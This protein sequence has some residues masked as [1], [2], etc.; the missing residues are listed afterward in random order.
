MGTGASDGTVDS[1]G[2][3]SLSRPRSHGMS[4]RTYWI[5]V[6]LFSV[7]ALSLYWPVL[8]TGFIIDDYAQLGMI[9]GTYP[10]PRASLA[11]FTFS[12]GSLVENASLRA[13][14]F[15][16][17]WSH[18]RLRISLF[19]PLASAIMWCDWFCF[20]HDAYAYHLHGAVWWL[21]MLLLW[22]AVARRL[23]PAWAALLAVALAALHPAQVGLLGWIANRNA[24]EASVFAL[25]A[26]LCQLRARQDGLRAG[27]AL[28]IACAALALSCSEYALGFLVY[29]PAYELDDDESPLAA[30]W[31]R[32]APWS[33][34]L[35]V[36]AGTRAALGFGARMSGM[37]ADPSLEPLPFL[38]GALE[39]YP[40][41]VGDLVL[42]LRANW[43]TAGFPWAIT[44]R[45]WGLV[46]PWMV[47]DIRYF[48]SI[49]VAL[50][51]IGIGVLGLVGWRAMRGRPAE[52]AGTS[53]AFV[54][55][56]LPLA[57]APLLGSTPE[58]RLMLPAAFGWS[59]LLAR[60]SVLACTAGPAADGGWSR[61]IRFSPLT[62]WLPALIIPLLTSASEARNVPRLAEAVRASILDPRL[63][64][65]IGADSRVLLAAAL[66]PTTTLYVPLLRRWYG[67]STP[68]SCHLLLSAAS[69]LR[70]ERLGDRSFALERA[71]RS[72]SASDAYAGIFNREPLREGQSVAAGALTATIERAVEGRPMRVRYE[73]DVSLDDPRTV[74][75]VQSTQGLL[76]RAFPMRGQSLWLERAL[77]PLDF[78]PR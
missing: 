24:L 56:A 39:R 21:G 1:I 19:R 37:Y 17:W 10:V 4:T 55:W 74:L 71:D 22:A 48:R 66:D 49:H 29:A 46:A 12:D 65:S 67:R 64:R 18:P 16:P 36:Y 2:T 77:P 41:L 72:Y 73:L 20:G 7:A 11:L 33:A 45:N 30:R 78:M 23:L 3:N 52:R 50:G 6:S 40:V 58:S 47:T 32:L 57:L 15:L 44:F 53:V 13:V 60:Y 59:I 68:A 62:L 5:S 54:A 14:G 9:T 35:L 25:L 43:W 34:L 63:D 51:V 38:R 8:R 69:R 26:L 27:T 70:L 28:A 31:R 42:G 61:R 75:L 76:R